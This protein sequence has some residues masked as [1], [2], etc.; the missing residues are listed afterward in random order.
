MMSGLLTSARLILMECMNEILSSRGNAFTLHDLQ[1]I[2][3]PLQEFIGLNLVQK[4]KEGKGARER[5]E[6]RR[7]ETD[8]REKKEESKEDKLFVKEPSTNWD[9][10]GLWIQV[11][12]YSKRL[13]DL[14]VY[15]DVFD[16]HF[17][18]NSGGYV[19]F[20]PLSVI[21]TV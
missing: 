10:E 16:V 13:S 4:K 15:D 21:N 20:V 12:G 19:K 17:T 3:K 9:K 2:F 11:H 1:Q 5:R 14:G 18:L 7:R 8:G 6:Q